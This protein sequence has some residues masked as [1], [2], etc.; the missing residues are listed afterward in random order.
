MQTRSP[1]LD[2]WVRPI[3]R[4]PPSQAFQPLN[5]L[6]PELTVERHRERLFIEESLLIKNIFGNLTKG[7]VLPKVLQQLLSALYTL[8]MRSTTIH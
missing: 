7:W 2:M 8:I 1:E 5:N 6:S 3:Q 4:S